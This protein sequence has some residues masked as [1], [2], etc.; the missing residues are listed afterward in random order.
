M[1]GPCE[2]TINE[3][4]LLQCHGVDSMIEGYCFHVIKVGIG[5]L[6]KGLDEVEIAKKNPRTYNYRL[7]Q[8]EFIEKCLLV[9]VEARAV[10]VGSGEA[11]VGGKGLEGGGEGE[12]PG[13][14]AGYG[15]EIRI[16]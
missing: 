16:P 4:D 8:G 2:P 3:W 10:A 12:A 5:A 15:E 9:L 14:G 7:N 6:L 1:I 13:N 11:V